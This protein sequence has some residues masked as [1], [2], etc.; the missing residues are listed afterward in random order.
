[1]YMWFHPISLM[2]LLAYEA[3]LKMFSNKCD[4]LRYS[5]NKV[6]PIQMKFKID[7]RPATQQRVITA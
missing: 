7:H 5:A 1:M 2:T 6:F 3:S 4:K